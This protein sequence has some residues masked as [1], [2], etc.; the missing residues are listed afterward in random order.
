MTTTDFTAMLPAGK[1][2]LDTLRL[3]VPLRIQ[4]FQDAG[5][6]PEQLADIARTA[7][8]EFQTCDDAL[9]F[10]GGPSQQKGSTLLI[11]MLAATALV[12]WGGITFCGIHWCGTPGCTNPDSYHAQPCYP[13]PAEEVA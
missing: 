2:L 9:Q 3:C 12:A 7:S 13:Q 11:R 6:S 10:G 1:A 4:E 5:F 8:H